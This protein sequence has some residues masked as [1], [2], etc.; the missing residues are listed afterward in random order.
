MGTQK[1]HL[2][3]LW[4]VL[5]ER[6]RLQFERSAVLVGTE[7]RIWT[8][9]SKPQRAVGRGWDQRLSRFQPGLLSHSGGFSSS[10]LE[11]DS[12]SL[13][14]LL[15]YFLILSSVALFLAL[16]LTLAHSVCVCDLFILLVLSENPSP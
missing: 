16:C 11:M 9:K 4:L 7:K 5:I 8:D 13:K 6:N 2:S 12:K 15:I 3:Q 1:L 14:F 10:A